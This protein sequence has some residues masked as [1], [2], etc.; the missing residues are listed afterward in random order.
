MTYLMVEPKL[1]EKILR[2]EP[3]KFVTVHRSSPQMIAGVA[4]SFL[5]CGSKVQSNLPECRR[6]GPSPMKKCLTGTG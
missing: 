6:K 2:Q 4:L 3:H 5:M 1:K